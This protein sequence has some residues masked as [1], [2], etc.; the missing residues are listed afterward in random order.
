VQS[1]G[2]AVKRNLPKAKTRTVKKYI[3]YQGGKI[4]V[5]ISGRS[6]SH[7]LVLLHGFCEDR[8]IWQHLIPTLQGVR[9]ILIDLPGF[10]KSSPFT[11]EPNLSNYSDAVHAVAQAL[12][13][14]KF[15]LLGHSFGGYITLDFAHT[16]AQTLNGYGLIH[17]H[18]MPDSL[19]RKEVRNKTIGLIQSGKNRP[20]LRQLLRSLFLPNFAKE[21]ESLVESLIV[22]ANKYAPGGI[23]HAAIAM[24]DRVDQTSVISNSTLP[25]FCLLGENDP[26]VPETV[27]STFIHLPQKSIIRLLP[28][29]AHMAMFE[30]AADTAESILDFVHLCKVK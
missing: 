17:S 18:P 23:I 11:I 22:R 21:H 3:D 24:R 1:E 16:F 10:G 26:L 6:R 5:E 19:E 12:Q 2:W 25:F 14:P 30:N 28:D 7:T 20:F 4:C 15:T 8:T 13:L 29:V 27:F 9:V